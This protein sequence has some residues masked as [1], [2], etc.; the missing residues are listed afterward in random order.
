M[1][2]HHPVSLEDAVAAE[3]AMR[4]AAAERL[5]SFLAGTDA[6]GYPLPAPRGAQHHCDAAVRAWALCEVGLHPDAPVHP[7]FREASL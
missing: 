1:I 4:C 5:C 3:Y 6:D 2:A 7:R